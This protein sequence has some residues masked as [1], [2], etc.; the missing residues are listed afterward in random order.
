M[1]VVWMR[2]D[3]YIGVSYGQMPRRWTGANGSVHTFEKLAE[4]SDWNAA[5]NFVF[6]FRFSENNY[7]K[8]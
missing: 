8:S 3:G 6:D 1:Y 7:E 5:H 2:N 4:F